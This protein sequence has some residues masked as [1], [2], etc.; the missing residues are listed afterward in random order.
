MG[1]FWF[2]GL[3]FCLGQTPTDAF[4]SGPVPEIRLQL[5][6][7]AENALRNEPRTYVKAQFRANGAKPVEIGIKIKGAAGSTRPYD[8]RPALTLNMDKYHR[9][10]NFQGMDKFHL[11]NSVQDPTYLNELI[12]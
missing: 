4:F 10:Q 12:G 9:G 1:I 8:D 5:A 7:D 11:N 2:V 6:P 3:A